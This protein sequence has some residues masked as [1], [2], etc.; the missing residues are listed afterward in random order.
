VDVPPNTTASVIL[1]DRESSPIEV[2][3]G[4]YRWSYPYQLRSVPRAPLS[5]DSTLDDLLDD[6]EVY[7]LVM[8]I[9]SEHNAE[10]ADR[11]N[12]QSGLTLRQITYL[13]PRAEELT[14]KIEIA[15]ALLCR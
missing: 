3:S 4:K 5:L 9:I 1:P 8:K 11:V 10:F 6:P 14:S 7:A 12:G 15:L 2:G 13:N